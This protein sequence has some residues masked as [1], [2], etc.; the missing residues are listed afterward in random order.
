MTGRNPAGAE[1][2]PSP[3]CSDVA[4]GPQRL[5]TIIG[6]CEDFLDRVCGTDDLSIHLMLEVPAAETP[7]ARRHPSR[8]EL[9]DLGGFRF[10]TDQRPT[11]A[12]SAFGA[13]AVQSI[14]TVRDTR[15]KR[16]TTRTCPPAIGRCTCPQPRYPVLIRAGEP[17][18]QRHAIKPSR[19]HRSALTHLNRASQIRQRTWSEPPYGIEP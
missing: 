1:D 12:E 8:A 3:G 10:T 7:P 6:A 13:A 19:Y 16:V 15:H 2:F 5:N 17:G 14:L 11:R 18:L 9:D 4:Y